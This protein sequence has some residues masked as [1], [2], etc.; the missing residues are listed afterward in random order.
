MLWASARRK[1]VEPPGLSRPGKE[2]LLEPGEGCLAGAG[3]G[4]G[5]L[6]LQER[7]E[8]WVCLLTPF[9][10]SALLTPFP[11]AEPT[12]QPQDKGGG[13]LMQLAQAHLLGYIRGEVSTQNCV[14]WM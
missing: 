2:G 9:S 5:P 14:R 11:L 4:T 13:L 8:G 12:K 1:A 7:T 10:F 3:A 6:R